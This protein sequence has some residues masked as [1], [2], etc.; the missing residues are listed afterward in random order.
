[1][2]RPGFEPLPVSTVGTGFLE[3]RAEL[4]ERRVRSGESVRGRVVV[5]RRDSPAVSL[6]TGATIFGAVRMLSD[7]FLSGHFIGW[8][9]D[10]GR[11]ITV[12]PGM[13]KELRLVVGTRSCRPDF[14]DAIPAGS[15]EVITS[16]RFHLHEHDRRPG[17]PELLVSYGPLLDIRNASGPAA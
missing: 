16:F 1:V 4:E 17:A 9:A 13:E 7:D 15:Y 8:V 5:T 11:L 3:L 10:V 14:P 2:D 6:L 12:G